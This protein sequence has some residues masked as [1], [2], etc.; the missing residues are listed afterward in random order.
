M[1]L[2]EYWQRLWSVVS[3]RGRRGRSRGTGRRG[4]GRRGSRLPRVSRAGGR[5]LTELGRHGQQRRQLS[6]LGRLAVLAGGGGQAHALTVVG[7]Q[8]EERSTL[9]GGKLNKHNATPMIRLHR[10]HL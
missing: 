4:R 8:E 7:L 10:A 9:N 2:E 3:P 6:G 1:T 5:V